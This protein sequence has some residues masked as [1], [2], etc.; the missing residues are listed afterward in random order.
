MHILIFIYLLI[1]FI[2]IKFDTIKYLISNQ[3]IINNY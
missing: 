3:M 2:I 1:H